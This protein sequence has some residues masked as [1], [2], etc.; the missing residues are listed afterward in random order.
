MNSTVLA[1]IE[2]DLAELERV[3]APPTAP[4]GYGIDLSCTTDLTEDLAEVDPNSPIAIAEALIRRFITPRGAL[5]DDPDYGRDVRG[6]L[7]RGVTANDLRSLSGDLRNEAR[8]DDRVDDADILVVSSA[9]NSV[10]SIKATIT[11]ADIAL[12]IFS[13]TF[14][15]TDTTALIES[16]G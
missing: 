13:L 11:P 5:P 2:A 9:N 16:I 10:L 7:N 15:V 12:G 3:V 4:L 8:K 14:S 6:H 1:A